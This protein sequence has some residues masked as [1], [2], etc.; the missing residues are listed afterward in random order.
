MIMQGNSKRPED[1]RFAKLVRRLGTR[2]I[3]LVGMMGSGKTTVGRRL[4]ARL[5]LSF[6]DADV[7][8]ERAAGQTIPEI[9]AEHGEPYFRDGERR[10]ILRL[11]N[12]PPHVLATG[13]GAFMNT[14][15]RAA[16]R[17]KAISIW[18]NAN[19]DVLAQR[20]KRKSN[21]PLLDNPDPEATIRRLLSER[22]PIYA[23]ADI[24]V[25][26]RD[27]SHDVVTDEIIAAIEHYFSI[28]A[29]K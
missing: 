29:S 27:V 12:E 16:I 7:E 10:V 24:A 26:S 14:E 11:L 6:V 4:A 2:S 15:T 3:V 18:L 25:T 8:I 21:R 13:G 22:N 5:Q 9:F 17:A 28:K 20:L 1:E 23:E 19:F